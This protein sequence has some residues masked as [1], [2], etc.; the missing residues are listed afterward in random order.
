M[1]VEDTIIKAA[2]IQAAAATWTQTN[3]DRGPGSGV[4]DPQKVAEMIADYA[5]MLF[6]ASKQKL[7]N[8]S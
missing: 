6:R 4:N 2:C 8:T 1:S 7:S 5:A 3:I